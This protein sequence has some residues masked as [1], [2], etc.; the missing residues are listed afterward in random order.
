[1]AQ[2]AQGHAS[3]TKR[4]RSDVTAQMACVIVRGDGRV[5]IVIQMWKNVRKTKQYVE[6][7]L[8]AKRCWGFMDVT[9]KRASWW[10]EMVFVEVLSFKNV[11][12]RNFCG[13]AGCLKNVNFIWKLHVTIAYMKNPSNIFF[14]SNIFL[15]CQTRCKCTITSHFPTVCKEIGK[16]F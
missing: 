12:V 15:L 14:E 4:T 10:E 7:T 2:T 6:N 3:V 8:N 9:A 5:S 16:Y 1:M 11:K 13:G